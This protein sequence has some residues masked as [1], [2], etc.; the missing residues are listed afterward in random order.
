[1]HI[2]VLGTGCPSS[3][4]TESV[5]EASL[6]RHQLDI[7]IERVDDNLH[8][9]LHA[10]H[11]TPAVVIDGIVVHEGSVPTAERVDH[12]LDQRCKTPCSCG[13]A[14]C[15]TAAGELPA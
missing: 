7:P 8:I 4:A 1:M 11:A 2:K 12:W 14:C 15:S 9:S 10:V 6:R 5:I 3:R 13:E